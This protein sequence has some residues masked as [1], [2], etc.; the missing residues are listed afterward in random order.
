M[1]IRI[2]RQIS[3][4]ISGALLNLLALE[5]TTANE[6]EDN[7]YVKNA[8][9]YSQTFSTVGGIDKNNIFFKALPGGNGRSCN[10]CHVAEEGWTSTAKGIQQRFEST[11]G[12]DPIFR[13]ND[14]STSPNAPVST[15]EE[16]RKAYSLLLEKGLIRVGLPM[17]ADAEFSLVHIDDPYNYASSNEL[18]MFRR[19]LPSTNLRLNV[20]FQSDL[21][22]THMD[23]ESDICTPGTTECFASV[24]QNLMAQANS[25]TTGHAEVIEGLT[26]EQKALIVAFESSLF[27]A[28]IYDNKAGFL[29]ED[30]ALGG[31]EAVSKQPFHYGINSPPTDFKTG[32]DFDIDVFKLFSAWSNPEAHA[33]KGLSPEQVEARLSI[34]RGQELFNRKT[35][36]ITETRGINDDFQTPYFETTCA[37]CHNGPSAGT[38]TDGIPVD[39]GTSDESRRTPDLPLYTFKNNSTGEIIKT[40]DPGRALI[41]GKWKDMSRLKVTNLR[42]LSS[43]PP[44]FHN[45]SAKTIKD[46]VIFYNERY[47]M[48]LTDQ[49]IEDYTNF[50][51]AL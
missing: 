34:A 12:T 45:G 4:A 29:N 44:Y 5:S 19:I 20:S 46:T 22:E 41:T 15:L 47:D 17:P 21:R 43:R 2:P 16:K 51:S 25:A 1:I 13:T 14:G 32:A 36:V 50:L 38:R 37:G 28:Q 10:T 7:G 33:G 42:G 35:F 48:K 11:D 31:P 23:P 49:E 8:N 39:I 6:L 30:M 26:I 24:T 40:T 3:F 27:T 9:G 18:S